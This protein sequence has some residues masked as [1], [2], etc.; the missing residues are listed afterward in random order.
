ME[1]VAALSKR[2]A[3]LLLANDPAAAVGLLLEAWRLTRC[4]ELARLAW[5]VSEQASLRRGIVPGD[6]SSERLANVTVLAG[7]RDAADLPRIMRSFFQLTIKDARSLL[8]SLGSWPADPRVLELALEIYAAPP[9]ITES[10][11][12]PFFRGLAKLM[13]AQADPRAN[14]RIQAFRSETARHRHITKTLELANAQSPVDEKPVPPALLEQV[15]LGLAR[16]LEASPSAMLRRDPSGSDTQAVYADML[17]QAGDVRGEFIALE[18][19]AL[20]GPLAREQEL[21]RRKLEVENRQRWCGKLWPFLRG[22]DTVRF[23]RG[24]P[25]GVHLQA[26]STLPAIAQLEEAT[27]LTEVWGVMGSRIH[28]AELLD[29]LQT[30]NL[31]ALRCFD[32]SECVGRFAG[33]THAERFAYLQAFLAAEPLPFTTIAIQGE[34]PNLFGVRDALDTTVMLDQAFPSLQQLVLR[35]D[36]LPAQGWLYKT[37]LGKRIRGVRGWAHGSTHRAVFGLLRR[38]TAI[39]TH[40]AHATVSTDAGQFRGWSHRLDRD[41]RGELTRLSS[42]MLSHPHLR[43]PE[44]KI[45][46][47]VDLLAALPEDALTSIELDSYKGT[48]AKP[49][50]ARLESAA[51]RQKQLAALTLFGIPSR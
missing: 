33:D 23:V 21:H 7:R 32:M 39:P 13:A 8:A 11:T 18:L 27:H 42:R 28:A 26:L 24:F 12:R 44:D 15:E 36:D 6:N 40:I 3:E 17:S 22:E 51:R 5:L 31:S 25:S 10:T 16:L 1:N 35:T 50:L 41:D 34:I 29:A 38:R 4:T 14:A 19:A 47:F 20:N 48:V 9:W 2:A 37:S 45:E 46:A 43:R 49:V 30:S